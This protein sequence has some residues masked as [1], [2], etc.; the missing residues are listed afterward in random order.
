[1]Q[2]M[3]LAAGKSTRLGALGAARPK[4]LVPICGYPAIAFGLCSCAT[5]GLQDVVINLHH[6]GDQI[7]QLVG[8]G[9]AFGLRVK[10]SDEPELLGT[11]G[12]LAAA[13]ALFRPGPVLVMNGK[14]VADLSLAQVIAAHRNASPGTLATMVLRPNPNQEKFPPVSLDEAGRVVGLRGKRGDVT[15][16]GKVSDMMFAGVHI[17]EPALLDRLP[18]AG[19][20]D[21]IA[22]AYQPALAD[23]GRVQ[24]FAMTG[25]FEEHSTPTRYLAGNLALVR[26]PGLVATTPG[27][28]TGVDPAAEV[29]ATAT[30]RPPIRIGAGAVIEAGAVVG[31]DVVVSGGGTV[32][33]GAVVTRAVVW[34]GAVARGEIAD[35]VVM[36]EGLVPAG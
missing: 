23:G 16:F 9:S 30:L 24:G 4:P 14:V 27:P 31:P 2:V 7:R 15:A 25:Y 33:A 32:A 36:E 20:S 5:A 11:G 17:L 28:L 3:I 34:P 26:Q 29:H 19:E 18:P 35:A 1:M 13:R 21:V 10:Y 6:H 22:A 12:G 8:D